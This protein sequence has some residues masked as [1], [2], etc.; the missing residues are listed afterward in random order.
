MLVLG[1]LMMLTI[2]LLAPLIIPFLF[3]A[4]YQDSVLIIM[5]L[6]LAVPARFF[7]S[8]AG[9]A[10]STQRH[11]KNKLYIMSIA[12]VINV[13]LNALFIPVYGVKGAAATTVLTEIFLVFMMHVYARH[14]VFTEFNTK[15]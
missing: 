13:I 15:T 4:H 8:S 10:L 9:S 3:G 2:W 14:R 1:L 7:A 12:A 6:G 5:V 11:L